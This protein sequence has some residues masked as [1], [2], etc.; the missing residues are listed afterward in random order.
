MKIRGWYKKFSEQRRH[1][2]SARRSVSHTALA[3]QW[4]R[5]LDDA[6]WQTVFY[7]SVLQSCSLLLRR[8]LIVPTTKRLKFFGVH[9]V[10]VILLWKV[11][12][13][14]QIGLT[15]QQQHLGGRTARYK[16]AL[17]KQY[18]PDANRVITAWSRVSNYSALS[19]TISVGRRVVFNLHYKIHC[20][21]C[22]TTLYVSSP[23]NM[24]L[25]MHPQRGH[26]G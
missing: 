20:K 26:S 15:D 18:V 1:L 14:I 16:T 21:S 22:Q 19:N 6:K 2:V 4:Q 8:C 25:S 12:C 13:S 23:G 10:P 7:L 11:R 9:F 24:I 5:P 3:R 17:T